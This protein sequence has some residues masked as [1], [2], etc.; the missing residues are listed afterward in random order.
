MSAVTRCI[1]VWDWRIWRRMDVG[2]CLLDIGSSLLDI[3]GC[4]GKYSVGF[5]VVLW[6]G[7]VG[8]VA[9]K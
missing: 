2:R 9:A 8:D 5:G 3:D 7:N 4:V 1:S 6:C